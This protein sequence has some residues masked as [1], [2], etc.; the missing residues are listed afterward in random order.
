MDEQELPELLLRTAASL[1]PGRERV[2][3]LLRE[4]EELAQTRLALLLEIRPQSLSELIGKLERDG[5][6]QRRRNPA[7]RRETLVSLTAAGEER[8]VSY[9]Q[10][11]ERQR[12]DFFSVLT[13]EEKR[14]LAGLLEK[15]L[16]AE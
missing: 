10:G 2:L 13:A 9:R 16:L 1:R 11:S 3:L 15:L 5:L 7:D 4:S 14:T 8:A 6:V 12:A